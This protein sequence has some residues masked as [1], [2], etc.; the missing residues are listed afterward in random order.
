M[1]S[2]FNL[3]QSFNYKPYF[4]YKNKSEINSFCIWTMVNIF[5]SSPC[6]LKMYAAGRLSASSVGQALTRLR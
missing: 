4:F 2:R 5:R 6:P 1:V 3:L